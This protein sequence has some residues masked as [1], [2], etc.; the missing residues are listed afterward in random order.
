MCLTCVQ[1]VYTFDILQT[2]QLRSWCN[3]KPFLTPGGLAESPWIAWIQRCVEHRSAGLRGVSRGP[4]SPGITWQY[5]VAFGKI[6]SGIHPIQFISI[7]SINFKMSL[8][9]VLKICWFVVNGSP[10]GSTLGQCSEAPYSL[11]RSWTRLCS[12]AASQTP[13]AHHRW[14]MEFQ[15]LPILFHWICLKCAGDQ[16]HFFI[17]KPEHTTTSVPTLRETHWSC[18]Q[19]MGSWF[20]SIVYLSLSLSAER[21]LVRS[22]EITTA[23][24]TCGMKQRRTTLGFLLKFGIAGYRDSPK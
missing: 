24:T 13:K 23:S 12:S 6:W 17:Y 3:H 2:R 18:S 15:L 22:H 1:D 8:P 5:L 11:H 7:F 16:G 20:K 10:Y 14:G 4:G 9:R 19:C 21:A